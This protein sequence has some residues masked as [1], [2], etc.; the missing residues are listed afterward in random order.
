MRKSFLFIIGLCF[1][2]IF[3][4]AKTQTDNGKIYWNSAYRLS[5]SDFKGS[6]TQEDTLL[7][8]VD[9]LNATHK[10]GA[11]SKSLDV[12]LTTK[13]GKT[14]FK[15]YAGMEQF[16]SWIKNKND[17]IS[18]KHEQGHFDICE[19]YA[20]ILRKEIKKAKTL[21]EANS[22]FTKIS[23]DE[24]Y[25]QDK[26]DNENTFESGGITNNWKENI[27]KRLNELGAYQEP[28]VTLPIYK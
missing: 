13:S 22:M 5:F 28:V 23:D 21:A 19:I 8:K 14:I 6:P 11:I 3:M 15:I 9:S 4:S 26:Y 24:N 12:Q 20:R 7:R 18:L 16:N 10:L 25:E 27:K 1:L 17:S 2:M